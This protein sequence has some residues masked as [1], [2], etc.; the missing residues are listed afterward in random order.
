MSLFNIFKKKQAEGQSGYASEALVPNEPA[1]QFVSLFFETKPEIAKVKI[2]AEL[3]KRFRQVE[4]TDDDSTLTFFFPDYTTGFST[5][6]VAA[7]GLV[8]VS[9][10]R[11]NPDRFT[12]AFQQ[13]WHWNDAEA[14]MENCKYEVNLI[15]LMS[16]GL[17]H[18]ARLDFFQRFLCA[19]IKATE[20]SA[21]YFRNSE[22]LIEPC[23]MLQACDDEQPAFLHGAMSVRLFTVGN[24]EMLMD[25]LGLHAYGL[26]DI[27]CRFSNYEPGAIARVLTELA[28]IVFETGNAIG[29]NTT[30]QGIGANPIWKT[31]LADAKT[32]P[33]RLVMS[34]V[35]N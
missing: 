23:D 1:L 32:T 31:Q 11:I 14:V 9:E 21:V 35:P 20:P 17:P 30:V 26:P 13:S 27:E 4:T 8:M 7:Q 16:K 5:G 24:G 12:T 34:I 6:R 33:A 18:Q 29:E 10:A 3:K 22:K 15:D 2:L 28:Y 25:T 19:V